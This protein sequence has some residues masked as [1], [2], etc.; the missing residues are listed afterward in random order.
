MRCPPS[1]PASPP[2]AGSADPWLG[3]TLSFYN[4][5]DQLTA[6]TDALGNTTTYSYTSSGSGVPGGLEYCSVDPV[7]YQASVTCPV[8]GATHVN[9]RKR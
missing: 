9:G 6:T 5:S 7:D 2:A 8:Y 3:M 1:A 4:G